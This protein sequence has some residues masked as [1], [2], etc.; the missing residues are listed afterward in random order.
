MTRR[1]SPRISPETE[2]EQKRRLERLAA[3]MRENLRRR[4]AQL[5]ARRTSGCGGAADRKEHPP[6]AE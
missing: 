1:T 2:A 6:S 5:C 3:A 4:K